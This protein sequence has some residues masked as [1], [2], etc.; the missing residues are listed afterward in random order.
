MVAGD[1][2]PK[3]LL[4]GPE[5]GQPNGLVARD[6]G[7]YVVNWRDGAFF[8]VDRAGRRT[9]LGRAPE[10][11]LDGLARVATADG[12]WFLATSWAG[13]CVYR[14]DLQGGCTAL[15]VALEQPADCGFD[16]RRGLLLVPLFGKNTLERLKL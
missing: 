13:R 4:R 11:Q 6:T 9:D 10:A 7:V 3:V 2:V 14:F 15:S 16:E 5:L 12:V 1:G 8:Q